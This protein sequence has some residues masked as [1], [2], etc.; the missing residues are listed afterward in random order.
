MQLIRTSSTI[1]LLIMAFLACWVFGTLY[2]A[3]PAT[4]AST[5]IKTA[6]DILWKTQ[7]ASL[8]VIIPV[9]WRNASTYENTHAIALFSWLSGPLWILALMTKAI[10]YLYIL[11]Y[12]ALMSSLIFI[13]VSINA[14]THWLITIKV[15]SPEP[16]EKCND[17]LTC[18]FIRMLYLIIG[19]LI[20]SGNDVWLNLL[21]N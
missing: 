20:F 8:L 10:S 5:L 9:F 21:S 18:T 16:G 1:S 7:I 17:E 13:S 12:L 3:A 6:M 11:K 19:V 15:F 2:T 14:C 4:E